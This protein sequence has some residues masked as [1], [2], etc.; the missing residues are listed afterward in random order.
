M[1]N[2]GEEG[3]GV[4]ASY[5]ALLQETQQLA[6]WFLWTGNGLWLEAARCLEGFFVDLAEAVERRKARFEH[7]EY[8]WWD[9]QISG[10][11][12][13]GLIRAIQWCTSR[14]TRLR[15]LAT[16]IDARTERSCVSS[17]RAS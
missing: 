15:R 7:V 3:S 10:R 9:S 14:A 2:P 8:E 12:W 16:R 6:W 13:G 11:V 17:D 5:R 4:R 1:S